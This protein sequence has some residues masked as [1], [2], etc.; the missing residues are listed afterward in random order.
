[1]TRL[2]LV[3]LAAIA[4][5]FGSASVATALILPTPQTDAHAYNI[6]LTAATSTDRGRPTT[7]HGD[8]VERHAFEP[9]LS[10]R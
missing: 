3:A 9:H 7:T 10:G 5:F 2:V 6:T 8:N 1:M 4:A